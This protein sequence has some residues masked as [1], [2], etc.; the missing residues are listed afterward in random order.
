MTA[1]ANASPWQR[2]HPLTPLLKGAKILAAAT[3]AISWQ[4]YAQLGFLGW[5]VTVAMVLVLGVAVAAV[6]WAVTGYEVIGRELR[7][8]EGLL[9]RRTRAIPLERVQAIDVVRPVLARLAGLADLRIEVIGGA[10]TEAPLAYLS[11][12]DANRLR[13]R[14]LALARAEGMPAAPAATPAPEEPAERL[15]HAVNNRDVLIGQLLNPSLWLVPIGVLVTVAPYAGDPETGFIAVASLLT[16]VVGVV[17]LPV[18]RVLAEWR[19]RIGADRTGL[20]LHHGL[21]DLRSQTIPPQRVQAVELRWPFV[22]R[23]KGWLHARIDVAGYGGQS[24][25]AGIRAGT[26]LPVADL[27]TARRVVAEVLD[28]V[29]FATLPLRPAPARARWFAPLAWMNLG[30]GMTDTVVASRDGWLRPVLV[31]VPLARIQSVRVVQ[32]PLQRALGVAMLHVDTA[33]GLHAVGR[34]RGVTEAYELAAALAAAS[35]AARR[36]ARARSARPTTAN[37]SPTYA[38]PTNTSTT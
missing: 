30:F 18:R 10:R 33:G 2:L 35:R 14:L 20:R 23:I 7:I 28:G 15:I 36:R 32:G 12:D 9:W 13:E 16:A 3:A 38:Q 26:L 31:I 24:G 27:D 19:F 22:W 8:Y 6:S 37:V 4:G 17:Q 21:L 11:L 29:D 5:L 34:H 25:A 1:P